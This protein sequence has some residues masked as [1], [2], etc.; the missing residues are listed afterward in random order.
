MLAFCQI[1]VNVLDH[2]DFILVSPALGLQAIDNA[3][4]LSLVPHQLLF[5]SLEIA[6]VLGQLLEVLHKI[7]LLYVFFLNHLNYIRPTF[8]SYLILCSY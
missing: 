2:I 4:Q 8:Y 3:P 1:H 6:V 7:H 5:F